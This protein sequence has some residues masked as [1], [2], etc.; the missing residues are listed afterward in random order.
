MQAF[1][2]YCTYPFIYLIAMLPFRALY[3]LSDLLYHV[4]R[5]SGYRK[6]VILKNLTLSFPGKSPAEI[7]KLCKAYFDFGNIENPSDG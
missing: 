4:L 7:N 5:L 2:F 3:V 1:F 6:K